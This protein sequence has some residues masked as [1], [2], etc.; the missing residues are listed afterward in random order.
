MLIPFIGKY[1]LRMF[2]LAI[3]D[4]V[5][6]MGGY[7]GG[8]TLSDEISFEIDFSTYSYAAYANNGIL[9]LKYFVRVIIRDCL[10][11]LMNLMKLS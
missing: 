6:F 4:S 5:Q 1:D 7:S 11:S 9:Y 8:Q 2:P 3:F 10:E